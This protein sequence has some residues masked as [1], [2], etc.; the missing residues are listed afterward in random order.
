MPRLGPCLAALRVLAKSN[1]LIALPWL[2]DT[3]MNISGL[4]LSVS[5]TRLSDFAEPSTTKRLKGAKAR[6]GA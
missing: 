6:I 2:K 4:I 1:D 5:P 3:S